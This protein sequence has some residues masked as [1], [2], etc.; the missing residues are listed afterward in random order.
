MKINGILRQRAKRSTHLN[1]LQQGKIIA[2]R[3][4]MLRAFP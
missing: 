4:P 3:L 1:T 2:Y